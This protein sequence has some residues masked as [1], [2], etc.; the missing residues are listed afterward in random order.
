MQFVV[1]VDQMENQVWTDEL[2]YRVFF[3][4]FGQRTTRCLPMYKAD[5]VCIVFFSKNDKVPANI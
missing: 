1:D 5:L 4:C 2:V 3:V